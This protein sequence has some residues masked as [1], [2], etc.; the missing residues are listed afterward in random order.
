M[1][2]SMECVLPISKLYGVARDVR[3][4]LK[5]RYI[6]TSEQLLRAAARYEDRQM[7]AQ[8]TYLQLEAVTAVVRRADIARVK[9]IGTGF[10]RLLA[11][12]GVVDVAIL[13][14][15]DAEALRLRLHAL[16]QAERLIKRS[17]TLDEIVDWIAQARRLPIVVSYVP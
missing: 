12:I 17:P 14:L 1:N 4:A 3:L 10:A 5:V 8:A 11:E 6:T 2:T 16:N 9:G 15:Q 7:L 13:A